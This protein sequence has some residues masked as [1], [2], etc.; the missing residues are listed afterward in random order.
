MAVRNTTK[1]AFAE[2]ASSDCVFHVTLIATQCTELGKRVGVIMCQVLSQMQVRQLKSH[3]VMR[4][5]VLT[6][7]RR[8]FVCIFRAAVDRLYV[9]HMKKTDFAI[10]ENCKWI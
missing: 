6:I 9:R 5:N 2:S 10:L 3:H 7:V 4:F 8:F 1:C